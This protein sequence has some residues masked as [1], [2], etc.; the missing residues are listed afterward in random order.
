MGISLKKKGSFINCCIAKDMTYA[1]VQNHCRTAKDT[2]CAKCKGDCRIAKDRNIC[3]NAICIRHE[4]A[5][6]RCCK[7][8]EYA[9]CNTMCKHAW[10]S[11]L[12]IALYIYSKTRSKGSAAKHESRKDG[13]VAFNLRPPTFRISAT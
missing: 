1:S 8:H 3:G 7:R 11:T 10:L 12:H 6:R 9:I 4:Y 5:M 2:K 13:R